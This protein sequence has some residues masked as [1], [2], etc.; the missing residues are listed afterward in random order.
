VRGKRSIDKIWMLQDRIERRLRDKYQKLISTPDHIFFLFL[1]IAFCLTGVILYMYC[2]INNLDIS[3]VE[4]LSNPLFHL[5]LGCVLLIVA[6]L[7]K[8]E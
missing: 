7:L 6:L 5:M 2:I 1:S 4:T 3:R 8:S